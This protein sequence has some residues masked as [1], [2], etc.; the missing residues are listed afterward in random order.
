MSAQPQSPALPSQPAQP[1]L[2]DAETAALQREVDAMLPKLYRADSTRELSGLLNIVAQARAIGKE[3][4]DALETLADRLRRMRAFDDLYILTSAVNSSGVGSKK[5]RRYE[6][7]ALIEMQVYETA[8]DLVRPLLGEGVQSHDGR[9]AYGNLGRIYKQMYI[10]AMKPPGLGEE[11]KLPP[12]RALLELYLQRS[13]GAYMYVWDNL[14][15]TETT[16][17]GINAV[18]MASIAE[19]AGFTA[20]D[21]KIEQLAK[22]VLAVVTAPG[23]NDVWAIGTKG[24]TYV[25]LGDY[26]K[27]AEAYVQYAAQKGVDAFALGSSLRQLEDVWGISGSDPTSGQPVRLLKAALIAKLGEAGNPDRDP[28]TP[29]PPPRQLSVDVRMTKQEAKLIRDEVVNEAPAGVTGSAARALQKTFSENFPFGMKQLRLGMLR[30]DAVCRIHGMQTGTWAAFASGFAIKGSLLCEAWGDKPV[31]IT[32]NHVISSQPSTESKRYDLCKAV[33]VSP[34]DDSEQEVL[35]ERILWES[36]VDAHDITILRTKGDLPAS[37]TPLTD[38]LPRPLGPRATDDSGIGRCYVIGYPGAK[39]LSF[40]FADNILLDHDCPDGCEIEVDDKGRRCHGAPAAPVHVHYRTPTIGGN[41]G[42]PVFD[43]D[44]FSLLGVHHS[45]ASDMRRLNGRPGIYAANEGIWIDSIRQAIA[46][47]ANGSSAEAWTGQAVRWRGFADD[48]PSPRADFITVAPAP[49]ELAPEISGS[50]GD[51]MPGVSP[52]ARQVL[53]PPGVAKADDVNAARLESV[54]GHDNRTRIFDTN[55]SPWRMICA[56]RARWGSRLMVGTGCFIG[57]NIILT[58]GHVVFPREIGATPDQIEI[59]PG[60]N[61]N[62]RPYESVFT[63]RVSM[64]DAWKSQFQI[65]CDIAAIHVGQPVGQRVGWFGVASR[66][67]QDLI[68]QWAHVTGYPGEKKEMRD[69]RAEADQPPAQA[70][71][72]WHHAAPVVKVENNRIFYKA[73]TTA[74][75][76]GSPIYVLH[77]PGNFASPTVVGVHAYGTQSTPG[78]VGPANSGAWID[79]AMLKIIAGWRTL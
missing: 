77:E 4:H 2:D 63:S 22:D 70:A 17:H 16:W 9:E 20:K 1:S 36:A 39:E 72:L 8:L 15:T 79:P 18:A 40:S 66:R 65:Q 30:A 67:P 50:P 45:G 7:Q 58:A 34:D 55:M 42:S 51:H 24:E 49:A 60:L 74:G 32:N 38:L 61:A 31:I 12:D 47:T 57:P 35:F 6:I 75:Q 13:F 19:R 10:N 26:A 37:V 73:D 14:K 54:I 3:G 48:P 52:V 25:A 53:Y 28:N 29:A 5:M 43:A 46:E 41:S 56:I 33:F 76:S 78:A 23:A 59:I 69:P 21:P 62:E 68:G 11:G 64:H 44:Y 71:Q 27:A